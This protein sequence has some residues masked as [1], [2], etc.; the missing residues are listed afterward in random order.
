MFTKARQ[1]QICK[2]IHMKE[3]FMKFN[4]GELILNDKK[5]DNKKQVL[6]VALSIANKQCKDLKP[7]QPK[8]Y[9]EI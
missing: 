4:D 3:M 1:I 7:I 2:Q 8:I 5:V 6:A 9:V